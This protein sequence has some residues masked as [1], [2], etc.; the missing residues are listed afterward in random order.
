MISLRELA[1]RRGVSLGVAQKAIKSGHAAAVERDQHSRTVGIDE[2]LA[3]EHWAKNTD[4]VEA[5]RNGK[6]PTQTGFRDLDTSPA[7]SAAVLVYVGAEGS[8]GSGAHSRDTPAA[9][10]AANAPAGAAVDQAA[11][12]AARAKREWY[13]AETARLDYLDRLSLLV[14]VVASEREIGAIFG[15]V[16]SNVFRIADRQ[17]QRLAA[18]MDPVRVHRL[19]S[20]EFR[21]VF[22]ALSRMFAADADGN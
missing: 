1:R 18:E 19:L 15:E 4:L 3:V 7:N 5:A 6:L 9:G 2:A 16:K 11:Y 13:Q 17:A 12:L 14:S 20:E 21:T 8:Q 10:S 22:D